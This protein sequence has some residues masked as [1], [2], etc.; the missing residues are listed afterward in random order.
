MT[1]F[2][3]VWLHHDF[4]S[5]G[6]LGCLCCLTI[7]NNITIIISKLVFLMILSLGFW[8]EPRAGCLPGEEETGK[9]PGN[10]LRGKAGLELPSC[11]AQVCP[12]QGLLAQRP[13]PSSIVGQLWHRWSK[14]GKGSASVIRSRP[15]RH[16]A[17]TNEYLLELW[18][19]RDSR[20]GHE[21]VRN[22]HT[23]IAYPQFIPL[24]FLP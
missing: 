20:G 8:G 9:E 21:V 3:L 12:W 14:R 6:Y 18:L 22:S 4:S 10:S 5:V 19:Y 17:K 13:A 1:A 24:T 15:F 7:I 11:L 2:Y 23:F 16:G